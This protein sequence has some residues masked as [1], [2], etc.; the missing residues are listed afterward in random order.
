VFRYS[1]SYRNSGYELAELED[2][3]AE[4]SMQM[5]KLGILSE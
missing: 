5:T 1:E 3:Y 2:C 4:E